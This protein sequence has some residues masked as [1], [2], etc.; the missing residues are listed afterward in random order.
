MTSEIQLT[1]Y[2]PQK[3]MKITKG[4]REVVFVLFRLPLCLLCTFP[5]SWAKPQSRLRVSAAWS[6]FHPGSSLSGRPESLRPKCCPPRPAR[7]E[8][9]CRCHK[10]PASGRLPRQDAVRLRVKTPLHRR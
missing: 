3:A 2:E 4:T 6:G 7:P 9:E 8:S 10:R 5:I 1:H